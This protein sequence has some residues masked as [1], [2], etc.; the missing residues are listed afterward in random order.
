MK[1]ELTKALEEYIEARK[2]LDE[3]AQLEEGNDIP[4]ISGKGKYFDLLLKACVEENK[5]KGTYLR[6]L[7]QERGATKEETDSWLKETGFEER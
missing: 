3:L 6:L 5:A 2:H 4:D 1:E 7:L